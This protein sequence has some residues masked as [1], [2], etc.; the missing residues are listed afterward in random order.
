[1][2]YKTNVKIIPIV[3]ICL[4]IL[5]FFIFLGSRHKGYEDNEEL[6]GEISYDVPSGFELDEYYGSKYYNFESDGIY[7]SFFIDADDGKYRDDLKKWFSGRIY[8]S[9]NDEIGELKEL[10]INDSK[11][12]YI[13]KKSNYSTEYYYGISSSNYYYFI[14]YRITDYDN[15]DREDIDSNLCYNS[16]DEIIST[17]KVK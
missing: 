10:T 16:K 15:G 3:V 1:M 5:C 8:Y 17:I 4:I 2:K 13:D 7:C 6:F 14:T 11:M 9:L 12:Y